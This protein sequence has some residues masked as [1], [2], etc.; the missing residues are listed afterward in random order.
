MNE[1]PIKKH[2]WKTSHEM[3]LNTKPHLGHMRKFG[4]KAYP[5]DKDIAKID[6]LRPCAHIKHLINYASLNI[7]RIWI[8]SQRKVIRTRNV[9]FDENSIY[10]K[11]DVD[12]MQLINE[13][14]IE[15]FK[16]PEFPKTAVR[17]LDSDSD[18]KIIINA[19]QSADQITDQSKSK[20]IDRIA[21]NQTFLSLSSPTSSAR[22][23]S[24]NSSPF[25]TSDENSKFSDSGK[26]PEEIAP[27]PESLKR[28]RFVFSVRALRDI[29]SRFDETNIISE[30]MKRIRMRKQAY[31]AALD[32]IKVRG[33]EAFHDS[34]S[35]HF[36]AREYHQEI[37]PQQNHSTKIY[38]DDLPP[39]PQHYD[40]FRKY[41]HVDDFKRAMS[42]E[43]K[44]LKSKG[45]WSE[46]SFDGHT[47]FIPSTWVFKYK[48]DN[49]EYLI[50]YKAQLCVRGDLQKI[51]Q[52]TYAA[53][54]A[55]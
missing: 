10:D 36:G 33:D 45:T 3:I 18:E 23:N 46:I 54:L 53:I 4:C 1:T 7:F 6:K 9:M 27:P 42:T 2:G 31:L 43:L 51:E 15:G 16:I 39:E 22:E 24:E 30:E 13:P 14:M 28:R 5:L 49:Q 37:S 47:V 21:F 44:A 41:S 8:P 25:L 55:V 11:S 19:T 12:L 17:E 26:A 48:F 40:D 20:E 32:R 38:R 50:K 29:S 35:A 52:D 34:F